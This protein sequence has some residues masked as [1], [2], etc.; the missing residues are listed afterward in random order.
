M[1]GPPPKSAKERKIGPRRHRAK[2]QQPKPI[3]PTK[4]TGRFGTPHGTPS[5]VSSKA[6]PFAKKLETAGV[7]V[8]THRSMW[9]RYINH[10][11]TCHQA[12]AEIRKYGTTLVNRFGDKVANPACAAMA[13][14][15]SKAIEI[16]RYFQKLLAQMGEPEAADPFEAFLGGNVVQMPKKPAK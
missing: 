9:T 5:S 12:A 2:G 8:E 4:N 1:P 7:D 14:H 10:L 15:S 16:E 6:R 3:T 13:S 11:S